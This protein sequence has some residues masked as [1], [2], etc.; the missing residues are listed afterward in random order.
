VERSVNVS[1][2]DWSA[3]TSSDEVHRRASGRRQHNAVR[4]LRAILRRNE[5]AQLLD[6]LGYARGVQVVIARRLGVSPATIS[7]DV[8][9]LLTGGPR[10]PRCGYRRGG[11]G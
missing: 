10:C 7:R 3:S 9:A 4:Q 1:R 6:Q 2:R 8:T 5:V 11:D